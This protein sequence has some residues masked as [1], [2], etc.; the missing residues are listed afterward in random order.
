VSDP[1][2]ARLL[3]EASLASFELVRYMV[4]AETAANTADIA[5]KV[6]RYQAGVAAEHGA[7]GDYMVSVTPEQVLLYAQL[8][9]MAAAALKTLWQFRE[10]RALTR[11]ELAA[12][13]A[14]Y[15]E[16]LLLGGSL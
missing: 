16:T 4:E 8:A 3:A 11:E 5:E 6:L 12:E 15:Q 2:A 14:V 1:E 10:G 7:P 9:N 13:L